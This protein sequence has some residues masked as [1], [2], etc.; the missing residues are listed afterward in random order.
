MNAESH[1]PG[2]APDAPA[3]N[4]SV[5]IFGVGTAGVTMLEA[6]QHGDFAGAK[7]AVINADPSSLGASSAPEKIHLETKVL[8][9]LGTGGDPDRGRELAESHFAQLKSS[10]AGSEVV[11]IIAGLGGGAGTGIAPVLARAAKEAGALVLA[12]VTLPFDCEGNRRQAQAVEGLAHLKASADGVISL[13]CQTALKLI[14]ENMSVVDTFKTTSQ[15]LLEGAR[16]VWRLLAYRG[17]IQIHFA[18]LCAMLRD[19]H[20]ESCFAAVEAA[21][22]TRSRD[23]VEKLFAHP[24]LNGGAALADTDA[25]LVSILGGPDLTMSEINRVM[26]QIKEQCP[27]AQI[28]MGAAVDE[29]FRDHLAVTLIASRR[30]V[31]D[32]AK[33]APPKNGTKPAAEDSPGFETELLHQTTTKKPGSRITPPMPA[34]SAEQREQILTQQSG[35]G[36]RG[37]KAAARMRQ[38][39]LPLEIV[40]KNRFD[41]TQATIHNGEDLDIPTY[42]RRGLNLN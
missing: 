38:A 20:G 37:R 17:L 29:K 26:E 23:A 36:G 31:A 16:G 30:A 40:S 39:T 42:I 22:T 19:R 7:F 28:M 21:G 3:Q 1:G 11:F 5:K 35:K 34:L 25:A 12:F 13:P 41:K 10:C 8:R 2:V 32:K 18:D 24:M 4:I 9:G 14:D 33:A 15:L 27:R 6:M